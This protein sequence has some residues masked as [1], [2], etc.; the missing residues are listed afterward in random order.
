[1]S[2]EFFSPAVKKQ[3]KIKLYNDQKGLCHWC[4]N[5]MI[6]NPPRIKGE[7]INPR[8]CTL[9]HLYDKWDPLRYTNKGELTLVAACT[10][11]NTERSVI[12]QN[13]QSKETLWMLSGRY[14]KG[15]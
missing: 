8:M 11:C 6:F 7:R 3:I 14:P 4:H 13:N 9:D 10:K 12:N 2:N 5:L 1:M 15:M